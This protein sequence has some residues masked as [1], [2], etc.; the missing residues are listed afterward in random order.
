M[1]A[2][3]IQ[4]Y[5]YSILFITMLLPKFTKNQV[6]ILEVFFN[7]PEKAFYLRELARIVGKEPGVFQRD[8]E[9]LSKEGLLESYRDGNRRFFRLNKNY[10][11]YEELK[12]MFFKT[13]GIKG[14]LQR[15]LSKI[16]GVERAF[17]YGSFAR[18][19]E[20]GASDIDLCVIGSVD[21][22]KLLDIVGLLEEKTGR[23]INY[24]LIS[25]GE[26]QRKIEEKNSFLKNILNQPKIELL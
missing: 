16:E 14:E 8:I 13:V 11:L 23:E 3:R 2:K 24:T 21:E 22:N 5:V 20:T 12:S 25:K 10:P 17:I 15:R 4:L 7:H 18:G 26:F 6:L 9:T 19:E 1:Y